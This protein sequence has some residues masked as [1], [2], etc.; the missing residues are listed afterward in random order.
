M[1]GVTSRSSTTR[2]T[3]SRTQRSGRTTAKK[4]ESK[5]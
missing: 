1:D 5:V 4:A 3:Q 2:S